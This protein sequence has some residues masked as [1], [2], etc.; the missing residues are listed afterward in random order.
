MTISHRY[1]AFPI[2]AL[3]GTGPTL[4]RTEKQFFL[5]EGEDRY[6]AHKYEEAIALLDQ[7]LERDPMNWSGNYLTAL[8]YVGLYHPGS[9][10]LKDEDYAE[11]GLAAF[12]KV[13]E[14][15]PPS[16]EQ[17]EHAL[18][19]FLSFLTATNNED[20]AIAYLEKQL[21]FSRDD[22]PVI[23]RLA[24]LYQRNGEYSKALQYFEKRAKIDPHNMDVW[25]TL[26]ENC[27]LR[28][29]KGGPDVSQEEREQIIGMGIQA[30]ENA[31]AIAPDCFYA[32]DY[33]NL[34]Y[35]EKAKALAAVGRD[36]EAREA[37]DKADEY[38]SRAIDA[39]KAWVAKASEK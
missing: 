8:S 21:A 22:P 5:D 28:L 17:R 1:L 18:T 38:Q 6:K 26:G 29:S 31:L 4:G 35:R 3:V 23:L 24:T 15:A 7:L 2:V 19:D 12:E 36:A 25:Y 11:K 27:W 16:P 39:R 14:L 30:L 10:D 9:E 37:L 13:L 33:I 34:I 32:L 20:K